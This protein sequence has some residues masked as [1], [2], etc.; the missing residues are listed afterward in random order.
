MVR[1]SAIIFNQS[2]IRLGCQYEPEPDISVL[3]FEQRFYA[4]HLPV[5]EDVLLIIEVADSTLLFDQTTKLAAYARAGIPEL[6][7]VDLDGQQVEQHTGP[8]KAVYRH[9]ALAQRGDMI[10]SSVLPSVSLY[11]ADILGSVSTSDRPKGGRT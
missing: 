11:V 2:P 10:T 5:A 7:I 3:Q 1:D 9:R 4:D 8:A 6:W